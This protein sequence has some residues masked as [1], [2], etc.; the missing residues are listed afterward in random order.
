MNDCKERLLNVVLYSFAML[1]RG[2]SLDH[3]NANQKRPGGGRGEIEGAVP[4]AAGWGS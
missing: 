3:D 2:D 4:Y 1:L